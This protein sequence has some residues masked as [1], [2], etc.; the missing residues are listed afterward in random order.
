MEP[1]EAESVNAFAVGFGALVLATIA[2]FL[3]ASYAIGLSFV[4]CVVAASGAWIGD[5]FFAGATPIMA[6][7][8]WYLLNSAA[9]QHGVVFVLTFVFLI[10]PFAIMVFRFRGTFVEA[11]IVPARPPAFMR[12]PQ[13]F[14]GGLALLEIG[15]IAWRASADLPGQQGFAFG[16]GTAPRL[17]IALLIL[18]ALA[19]MAIGLGAAGPT[20]D[21][22]QVRGPLVVTAAVLVFAATIRSL[23]LIPSTFLLVVVSSLATPE[24]RWKETVIWGAVLAAFCAF[25]FPYVLNLPMQLWPRW[26]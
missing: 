1:T 2:I 8:N 10:L 4:A 13:D 5:R 19:I 20:H 21:R 22:Y 17:F 23:G 11:R 3:P 18:N 15:L 9:V 16:P 24:V 14:L 25:L 7:F 6:A 26:W 12:N